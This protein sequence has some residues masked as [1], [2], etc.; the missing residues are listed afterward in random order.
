MDQ[1][2]CR[3]DA[4]WAPHVPPLAR[5]RRVTVLGLGAL[6][7]AVAL[8]LHGLN[9]DVAGWSRTQKDIAGVKC[10][11]GN[12]GLSAALDRAD[13]L[14]LLLPLTGA[15]ENLMNAARLSC[16]PQGAVV[17]NPGRG[18]LIDDDALIRALDNGHIAH[19]TLDVFR[20]EPLPPCHPFWVHPS[21]T[22]TPH[23]ASDTRAK[24][25]AEVIAENIRRGEAG[26]PFLHLVNREAGY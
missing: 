9:F 5:D 7:E 26:Q 2:I 18:P 4:K 25:A 6:G 17:I 12:D 21:A 15:T 8:A 11:A 14:I 1:D 16:L 22:V 3:T 10:L 19:A 23:I 20:E 13:I 24:S